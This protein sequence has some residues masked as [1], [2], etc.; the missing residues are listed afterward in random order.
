[1]SYHQ[2]RFCE[3]FYAISAGAVRCC[4]AQYRPVVRPLGP[5][6][7][8]R[9]PGS[10]SRPLDFLDRELAGEREAQ[11]LRNRRRHGV[12]AGNPA[13]ALLI[14][15]ADDAGE[16]N[17]SVSIRPSRSAGVAQEAEG[18]VLLMRST[19][20]RAASN[21]RAAVSLRHEV[22]LP[23]SGSWWAGIAQKIFDNCDQLKT[24]EHAVEFAEHLHFEWRPQT[25]K[26][27][28]CLRRELRLG[29]QYPQ[30]AQYLSSFSESPLA[31]KETTLRRGGRLVSTTMWDLVRF[32]LFVRDK[33]PIVDTVCEIGGGYG[34]P[35]RICMLLSPLPRPRRYII[36]DL[37]ESIFLAEIYLRAQSPDGMIAHMAEGAATPTRSQILLCPVEYLHHL[38]A[39][40]IQTVINTWS[41]QEMSEEW[42]DFYM[43]WLEASG[44]KFFY[45]YN[46]I[47]LPLLL[48]RDDKFKWSG[49]S[50]SPR[51]S[52]NWSA[53][54]IGKRNQVFQRDILFDRTGF[55]ENDRIET[56]GEFDLL[57][58]R[59]G[60][61]DEWPKMMDCL[62]RLRD[63]KRTAHFV[64]LVSRSSD[65]PKE[66]P[67]FKIT[68]GP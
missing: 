19:I 40:S 61:P 20:D 24:P 51:P 28:R 43:D 36:V 46:A 34:A 33:T 59:G 62:R 57:C 63:P 26:W 3:C 41:M 18:L 10:A 58:E 66:L 47:G 38:D 54:F 23:Q 2:V 31:T 55:T 37:A 17:G 25:L 50:Y 67:Y 11:Q 45:S 68:G 32:H 22:N 1:M 49:N 48:S 42:V 6:L 56:E 35:A 14:G 16:G 21:L 8:P 7:G 64:S 27:L 12:P 29:L 39:S 15:D 4:S 44:A 5:R 13:A 53:R 60:P 30:F 9:L 52:P 65:P